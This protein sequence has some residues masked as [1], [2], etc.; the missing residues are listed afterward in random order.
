MDSTSPILTSK[1]TYKR[2]MEQWSNTNYFE[3]L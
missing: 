2:D 3:S 1:V